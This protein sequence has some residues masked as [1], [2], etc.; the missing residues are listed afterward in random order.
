MVMSLLNVSRS[1]NSRR[2]QTTSRHLD[3]CGLKLRDE[4][5]E[6]DIAFD[7]KQTKC[8]QNRGLHSRWEAVANN[9][10]QRSS[11]LDDIGLERRDG[12]KINQVT[13]GFSRL[14]LN[15]EA[16]LWSPT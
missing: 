11:D 1:C 2:T 14:R 6:K 10:D 5:L 3:E 9:A 16:Q 8:L 7:N 12:C 4:W 13:Q 15:F